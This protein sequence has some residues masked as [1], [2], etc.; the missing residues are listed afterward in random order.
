MAYSLLTDCLNAFTNLF[1]LLS[2]SC[3]LFTKESLLKFKLDR[4][5]DSKESYC[6]NVL[7]KY[8]PSLNPLSASVAM[9]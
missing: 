3:G 5:Y 9:I 6:S 7:R 4:K 8:F 1:S 2:F